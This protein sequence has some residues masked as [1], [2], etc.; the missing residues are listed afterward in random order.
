MVLILHHHL[1]AIIV[2]EVFSDQASRH[3]I[4]RLSR[5]FQRDAICMGLKYDVLIGSQ[6]NV[7]RLSL[8]KNLTYIVLVFDTRGILNALQA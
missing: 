2:E 3:D 4:A 7:K 1:V 6:K 5:R 8:L